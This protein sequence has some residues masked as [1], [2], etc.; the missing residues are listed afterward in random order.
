[1]SYYARLRIISNLLP[2][3]H[4]SPSP[5]VL[6]ILNGGK[7]ASII[8]DDIGLEQ[9]WG[10]INLV[11]HA[12]LC[13]SLAFDYLAAHDAEKHITFVHA[14][15]GFVHTHTERKK[16]PT[17]ANGVVL[18]VLRSLFQVLSEWYIRL[19]GM[20]VQES[21]ERFAF[22]LMS[23]KFGPGSWRTDPESEVVFD[24]AILQKYRERDWAEKIWKFTEGVWEKALA[25]KDATIVHGL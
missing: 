14:L 11:K 5:R 15:P 19:F 18:W 17:M 20:A 9:H 16:R 10:L 4:K 6:S 12:T 25:G 13:T 7:E 2:L 8:D 1:M 22:I 21:G 3:L 23:E 24:N